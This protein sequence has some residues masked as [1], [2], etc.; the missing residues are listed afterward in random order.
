MHPQINAIWVGNP[1]IRSSGPQNR[2]AEN[3]NLGS[4]AGFFENLLDFYK[5]KFYI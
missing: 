2:K 4:G 1:N 3:A 5:Y